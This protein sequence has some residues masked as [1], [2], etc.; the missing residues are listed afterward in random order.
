L[1]S[2]LVCATEISRAADFRYDSRGKRDPFVP[3]IGM[4]RPA[5]TK[6]E[7]I[8]SIDDIRLEGIASG[9]GKTVAILNG[10]ALKEGDRAGDVELKKIGKKQVTILI[11]GKPYDVYLPGEEGGS[12]SGR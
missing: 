7:D 10:E 2:F 6:L 4:D 5:V 12:K 1:A 11:G 9:G 3:L 8:A